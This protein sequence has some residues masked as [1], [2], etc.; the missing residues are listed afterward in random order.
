MCP[1]QCADYIECI[2]LTGLDASRLKTAIS[3]N[4]AALMLNIVKRGK[5]FIR[6]HHT[7]E[8]KLCSFLRRFFM[9]LVVMTEEEAAAH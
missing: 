5:L 7:V 3:A 8:Y 9:D 6:T 2:C 4:I 1:P